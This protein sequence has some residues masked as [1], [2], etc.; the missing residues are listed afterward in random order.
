MKKH[1]STLDCA[2]FVPYK[3]NNLSVLL[4]LCLLYNSVTVDMYVAL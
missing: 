3:G 2:P 1:L 4:L